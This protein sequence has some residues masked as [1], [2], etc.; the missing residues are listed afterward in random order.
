MIIKNFI[1]LLKLFKT[2][3]NSHKSDSSNIELNQLITKGYYQFA[4]NDTIADKLYKEI[5]HKF[6]E[7]CIDGIGD[8][9]L[10]GV[11]RSSFY[12]NNFFNNEL[13]DHLDNINLTASKKVSLF[14]VLGGKLVSGNNQSSGGGWHRDMYYEQYKIII[15]LSDVNKNN[16][17][18]CY[19]E[20]SH[21]KHMQILNL[22]FNIFSKNITR[23]SEKLI[24]FFSFMNLGNKK[25]LTGR[26]GTCI[27]FN[28]SGLHRGIN[29]LSGCRFSLT[30][31]LYPN[32]K[33]SEYKDLENYFKI[34]MN[35]RKY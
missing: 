29:I 18:F 8:L 14:S 34:P 20:N 2:K 19:F 28:S 5:D 6:S 35:L 16:G 23:Y 9:R 30:A 4:I 12:I 33:N 25:I 10:H 3:L 26:R 32:L 31:Y 13:K 1:F 7:Y 21:K 11:E 17:P 24:G 15:Y 27:V 22:L